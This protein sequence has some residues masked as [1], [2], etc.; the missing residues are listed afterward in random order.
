[1]IRTISI[2]YYTSSMDLHVEEKN[3][4]TVITAKTEDYVPEKS[5]RNSSRC[6]EHP[7]GTP[8][9]SEL[10]KGKIKSFLSPAITPGCP[11]QTDAA[12]PFKGN[13]QRKS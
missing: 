6:L 13:P 1:M 11:K 5:R 12:D 2:P 3:L 8:K 9:L 10:A 4:K 7:I